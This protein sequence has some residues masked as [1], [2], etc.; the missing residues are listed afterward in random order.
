M[1][2]SSPLMAYRCTCRGSR[3][4]TQVETVPLGPM[5][6]AANDQRQGGS[7]D[8]LSHLRVGHPPSS[9]HAG[10]TVAQRGGVQV[11]WSWPAPP[12]R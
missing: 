12:H 5:L 2:R 1:R 4:R 10:A 8:A 7:S 3:W 11:L 9:P 6:I